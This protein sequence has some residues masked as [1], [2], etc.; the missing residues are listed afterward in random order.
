MGVRGEIE[1]KD[2]APW[3]HMPAGEAEEQDGEDDERDA[4]IQPVALQREGNH[5]KGHARHG[6]GD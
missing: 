4:H 1:L 5:R 2:G 6:C 3:L